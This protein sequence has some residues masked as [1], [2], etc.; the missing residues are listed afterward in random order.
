M[1]RG[2]KDKGSPPPET[3]SEPAARGWISG[4][5]EVPR[6]R[7]SLTGQLLI[8]MPQMPDQRFAR[9]VIYMCAHTADGAM[10]LVLN[11]LFDG[12]DVGELLEQLEIPLVS[13]PPGL[14]VHYGGPVETGRG[15]VLHTADYRQDGT[16]MVDDEIGLTATIDVLRAIALGQGPRRSMLAL[17]YA[18]WSAGQLD[19]ELTT[20]HWIHAPPDQAI[21]FDSDLETKWERGMARLG[22]S[23]STLSGE[24]GHA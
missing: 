5:G 20:N 6:M 24:V 16:L 23:L 13:P 1:P 14:R 3:G 12:V 19:Q 7:T 15:F 22:G 17:G 4:L 18:G 2:N 9:T 8:S 11:R 10:G 21:L